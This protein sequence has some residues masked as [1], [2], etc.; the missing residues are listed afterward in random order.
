LAGPTVGSTVEQWVGAMAVQWAILRA[1]RSVA[2]RG[3]L[4]AGQWAELKVALSDHKLAAHL[5]E[6]TVEMWASQ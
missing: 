2:R 4:L 5:V 1:D 3:R 6:L